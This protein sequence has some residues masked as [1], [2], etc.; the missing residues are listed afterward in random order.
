VF[1]AGGESG[2]VYPEAMRQA[3]HGAFLPERV[4]AVPTSNV[5]EVAAMLKTI[6][7]QEGTA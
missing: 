4:P 7:A 5:K 3:M 2:G 1:E 6:H